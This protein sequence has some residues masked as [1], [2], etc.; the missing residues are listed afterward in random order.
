[1]EA[2]LDM[3]SGRYPSSDFAELKPRLVWDRVRNI[4]RAREGAKQIAVANGGTIPDRGLFGVFI[5][6]ADAGHSRVGELDEEMVFES[7]V[8]DRFLLG[9]TTWRIDDIT[10]QRVIVSPAPG[11][12]GKMPFWKG[13]AAGRPLAMGKAIGALV[14]NL[15]KMKRGDAVDLLMK[16]H[17]LDRLAAR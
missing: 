10:P 13:D 17:R 7:R 4:L 9:A 2:T 12:P 16:E 1:L 15:Q 8:G 6:G 11:E 5:A 14:R 3:L